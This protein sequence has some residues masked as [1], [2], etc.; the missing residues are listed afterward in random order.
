MPQRPDLSHMLTF[1]PLQPQFAGLLPPL[2]VESFCP[3]TPLQA[4]PA[5]QATAQHHTATDCF[6]RA[7]ETEPDDGASAPVPART[8]HFRPITAAW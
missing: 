2:P 6:G 4:M 5:A 1:A 3:E 8:D 7:M